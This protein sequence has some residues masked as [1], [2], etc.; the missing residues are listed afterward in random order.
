MNK[1]NAH[2]LKLKI[3]NLIKTSKTG[4]MLLKKNHLSY[5]V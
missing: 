3:Q 1:T 5:K 2:F 4:N